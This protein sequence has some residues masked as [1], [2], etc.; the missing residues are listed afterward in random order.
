MR[1]SSIFSIVFLV[2]L[3]QLNSHAIV[4]QKVEFLPG[5]DGPLPFSL[6]TGY[7]G[8]D[9]REETQVFYYFFE[10]ENNPKDDP[11]LLWLTGGPLCSA[12]SAILYEIGPIQLEEVD[13]ITTLPK[14]VLRQYS[15]TKTANILFVDFPAGAG[16]SYSTTHR[17]NYSGDY[18]ASRNINEFLRKWL[19]NHPQFISNPLYLGGDSYTGFTLPLYFVNMLSD[20]ERGL[21][22]LLNLKGYILG[23]PATDRSIDSNYQVPLAHGMGLISDEFYESLQR[24]CSGQYQL[25]NAKNKECWN[26]IKAFEWG[27]HGIQ[28]TMTLED[29]CDIDSLRV[30]GIP[31][32]KRRMVA[33]SVNSLYHLKNIGAYSCR[34]EGYLIARHWMNE[35]SVQDALHVRKGTIGEWIRCNY[36]FHYS[37]EV[38]SSVP[39]HVKL[40]AEGFRSLIYS[41]DHDMIVPFLGTQAWIRSL[42]YSIVDDWRKWLVDGQ[43][44]GFTRT[45]ANKMTFA[46]IKGAGHTAPEYKPK[47]CAS[48][49]MRW[50]RGEHL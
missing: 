3:C 32:T 7:I 31:S 5:F 20:N 45:Y 17:A 48:M 46:T 14:L 12:M 10:S 8:V 6:E 18:K 42:N 9:V 2:I 1:T 43:I 35:R 38:S 40:S 28:V 11:I 26:K 19:I 23:N 41:G 27:L 13:S 49:F 34:K 25:V 21:Q 29:F 50:I 47:Q 24:T 30:Y 22:P 33:E 37:Y 15:W 44:A 4:S 16:F 36:A 39:Y